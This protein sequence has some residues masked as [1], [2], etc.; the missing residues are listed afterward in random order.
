MNNAG[1][2]NADPRELME[3]FVHSERGFTCLICAKTY[4][5]GVIYPHGQRLLEAALAVKAH[6]Q[7]EHGSIFYYLLN[8][9]KKHTGLSDV[10]QELLRRFYAGESDKAIASSQGI[11]PSTVRNHRFKLREKERQARVFLALMG[12]INRDSEFIPIHKGATMVDDRYAVTL[13]EEKQILD[14]YIK[15]GKLT[16][17]PPK[18]KRK[19]IILRYLASLF[20]PGKV[21]TEK[22]VNEVIHPVYDDYVT[23]RRY[24]VEYGFM[25]RNR[26][27]SEYRLV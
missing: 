2:W 13:E 15:D 17:F 27:G 18:Q 11:S 21:Y 14:N 19:L 22:E 6:V 9:D 25:D 12:L 26:D 1:F 5:K 4:E 10:Q 23:L 20:Q 8:L 7:E 16:V 3:G 24:L